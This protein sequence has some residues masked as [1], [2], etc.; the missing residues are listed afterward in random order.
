[1][2]GVLR[3][4]C[5]VATRAVWGCWAWMLQVCLK[6]GGGLHRRQTQRLGRRCTLHVE[7]QVMMQLARQVGGQMHCIV[8]WPL[9]C[10]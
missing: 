9:H 6:H 1:M 5:E 4:L 7:L 3:Q 2:Y 10:P 8:F